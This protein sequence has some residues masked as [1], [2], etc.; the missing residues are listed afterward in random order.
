MSSRR[1]ER[2]K[3]CSSKQRH[4]TLAAA[5]AHIGSLHRADEIHQR[6]SAYACRFC[7]GFHVGHMPAT[8]AR[9]MAERRA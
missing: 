4:A 8:V 5:L 2:R 7:H 3:T 6:M 9:A 1:H